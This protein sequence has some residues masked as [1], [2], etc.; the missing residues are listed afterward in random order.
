MVKQNYPPRRE[1]AL[2]RLT[3]TPQVQVVSEVPLHEYSC[4][5]VGKHAPSTHGRQGKNRNCSEKV[6]P[7]RSPAIWGRMSLNPRSPRPIRT[8]RFDSKATRQRKHKARRNEGLEGPRIQCSSFSLQPSSLA[9]HPRLGQ[10]RDPDL[11]TPG[12][13]GISGSAK[14]RQLQRKGSG[15]LISRLLASW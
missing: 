9:C 8:A 3:M 5:T 2:E 12:T 1:G 14:R 10:L 6:R 11:R 4:L 7:A 15:L 13:P